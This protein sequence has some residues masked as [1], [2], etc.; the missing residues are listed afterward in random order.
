MKNIFRRAA[1]LLLC[2]AVCGC[3]YRSESSEAGETTAPIES[4]EQMSETLS[5]SPAAPADDT[6]EAV[7]AEPETTTTLTQET[8]YTSEPVSVTEDI[9]LPDGTWV[10]EHG[11]VLSCTDGILCTFDNST[12]PDIRLNADGSLTYGDIA[13]YLQEE[14]S[15]EIS[16][17]GEWTA[18]GTE[19]G[20]S[21][22]DN[23]ISIFYDDEYMELGEFQLDGC[24]IIITAYGEELP[25]NIRAE[26]DTLYFI[27]SG[28]SMPLFRKGS[29]AEKQYIAQN[30]MDISLLTGTWY[31]LEDLDEEWIFT[32][33][34]VTINGKEYRYTAQPQLYSI[35]LTIGDD[36]YTAICDE[37]D[38][39]LTLITDEDY[40]CLVSV[41]SEKYKAHLLHKQAMEECAELL[42][43]YPDD[44]GWMEMRDYG[45]IPF[46]A[47]PEYLDKYVSKGYFP[48]STPEELASVCYYQNTQPAAYFVIELKSDI[49]LSGYEWAP[50]GWT[51]DHPFQSSVIGNGHTISGLTINSDDSDVG[52]LG[53]ATFCSVKD[54][55]FVD[56][57]VSGGYHVGIVTGQSI[58][59]GYQNV[60]V[61]GSVAG[62]NAGSLAGYEANG[63]LKNCSAEVIVNGEEFDFL[64]WNEKEKHS[65]VIED[66][67]TITMDEDHTVHRPEVEG[68]RNLGWIVLRNG[69]QVLHRNAE[70]E[71]SYRYFSNS[72]GT[73]EI[74]LTAYVSG[75]Y[76][77]ISN[78]VTYTLE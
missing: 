19:Y 31:N 40:L 10:D 8:E 20:F 78:T 56:A 72:P 61:S 37:Y 45:D 70:N 5:A 53:W 29:D 26:S 63:T 2:V 33:D 55:N 11:F 15:C 9:S 69:D 27:E 65:I 50:M 73:Y 35:L 13:A 14:K 59:C 71:L 6:E 22:K 48:V 49:D 17:D 34:T 36:E 38:D 30:G 1:A 21:F 4:Q 7:T 57:D 39:S 58:C 64:S 42:S 54:V 3:S 76:V 23:I 44:D 32:E 16:L 51:D 77:P 24:S 41:N 60:N 28:V 43:R 47:D 66:P 18:A 25:I 46:L 62:G 52:F 67:V 12:D 74:Y 75:Q 68:Y